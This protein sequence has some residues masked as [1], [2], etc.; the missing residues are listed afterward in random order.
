MPRILHL[1]LVC[2]RFARGFTAH[3]RERRDHKLH[4][5]HVN[6]YQVY[7]FIWLFLVTKKQSISNR[8]LWPFFSAPFL[9]LIDP[10]VFS[11]GFLYR[12]YSATCRAPGSTSSLGLVGGNSKLCAFLKRG[13]N[14]T[15]LWGLHRRHGRCVFKI[16]MSRIPE[17]TK[18]NQHVQFLRHHRNRAVFPSYSLVS[19]IKVNEGNKNRGDKFKSS[20][21]YLV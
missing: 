6:L 21:R 12:G 4:Q 1:P 5:L 9:S 16:W 17:S 10:W 20:R 13:R 14:L 7:Y 18:K 2:P 15:Y 19:Q 11:G 3:L 8:S